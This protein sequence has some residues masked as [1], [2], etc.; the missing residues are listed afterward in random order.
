MSSGNLSATLLRKWGPLGVYSTK[1]A[2][3]PGGWSEHSYLYA[4]ISGSNKGKHVAWAKSTISGFDWIFESIRETNTVMSRVNIWYARD[5][6]SNPLYTDNYYAFFETL[7][8]AMIFRTHA[9]RLPQSIVEKRN[10]LF[11]SYLNGALPH[12]KLVFR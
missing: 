3:G 12:E 8:D 11:F 10:P 7:P 6:D 5:R 2:L 9:E 1:P 4:E